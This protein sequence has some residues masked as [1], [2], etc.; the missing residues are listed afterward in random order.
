MGEAF[1][2]RRSSTAKEQK[3]IF[4]NTP[5]VAVKTLQNALSVPR[6]DAAIA[7][8]SEYFVILC[9]LNGYGRPVSD[10][11]IF[12]RGGNHWHS[13]WSDELT[14]MAAVINNHR[15][16]GCG[17]RY[18]DG[19]CSN[20]VRRWHIANA[21]RDYDVPIHMVNLPFGRYGISAACF[22]DDIVLAGGFTADGTPCASVLLY[23]MLNA[24][25]YSN[26]AGYTDLFN[27]SAARGMC[28]IGHI[29]TKALLVAGG[30]NASNPSDIVDTIGQN[31]EGTRSCGRRPSL[32]T[33]VYSPTQATIY[34]RGYH[35]CLIGLGLTLPQTQGSLVVP[36]RI[37]PKID[38]YTAGVNTT[39]DNPIGQIDSDIYTTITLPVDGTPG[40]AVALPFGNCVLYVVGYRDGVTKNKGYLVQLNPLR[41][42]SMEFNFS[43]YYM[44]GGTIGNDVGY[45]A[46]GTKNGSPTGDVEVIQLLRNVPIYSGMKYKVGSMTS[47]ATADSFTFH[48]LN[49]EI[50]LSGYMKL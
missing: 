27:L 36:E 8:D 32:S 23:S 49:N 24:K 34:D 11:D 2:T 26:N 25:N 12:D 37:V 9:G 21:I 10:L 39:T 7:S 19:T 45:I 16:I 30:K 41:I 22:A 44:Q 3:T 31:A 40:S 47:E 4:N 50:K 38:V 6:Y 15:I 17:G 18:S 48:P 28:A 43:R 14:D 20:L 13:H 46:C 35:Y 42:T 33:P 1:L 5:M 29:T